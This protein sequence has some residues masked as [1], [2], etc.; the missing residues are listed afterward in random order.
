MASDSA[1]LI[2]FAL[3][4]LAAVFAFI[5]VLGG[6]SQTGQ[7]A[8]SQKTP[9]S[10]WDIRNAYEACASSMCEDGL[11]GIPTGYYD[12]VRNLYECQCQTS[13]PSFVFYRSP[14]GKAG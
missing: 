7:L 13:N 9:V 8:G 14:Y 3:V 11:P 4:A 2:L 12:H 1:E 10:S 6:P 5:I